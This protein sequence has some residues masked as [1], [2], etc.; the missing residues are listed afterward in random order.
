MRKR[1]TAKQKYNREYYLKHKGD[2][3]FEARRARNAKDYRSRTSTK[4]RRNARLRAKWAADPEYRKHIS[5][6]QKAWRR[7]KKLAAA[8]VAKKKNAS[9]KG[10]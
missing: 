7:R 4:K 3:R 2:A 1:L 6:Y 9:R 10:K 8:R 5:E